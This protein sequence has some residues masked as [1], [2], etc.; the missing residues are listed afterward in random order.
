ME[1]GEMFALARRNCDDATMGKKTKPAAKTGIRAK[2]NGTIEWRDKRF[3]SRTD[4]LAYLEDEVRGILGIPAHEVDSDGRTELFV[5]VVRL[6]LELTEKRPSKTR[7]KEA[8]MPIPKT[9][10][11]PLPPLK[12]GKSD[13]T[14]FKE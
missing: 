6:Q 13:D 3:A 12:L 1:T 9:P 14:Y 8:P 2:T 11:K 7:R 5:R 4:L 10:P